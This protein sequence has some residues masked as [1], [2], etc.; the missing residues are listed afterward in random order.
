MS[1]FVIEAR[2]VSGKNRYIQSA[3]LNGAALNKPWFYHEELVKGG[4]LVLEMGPKPNEN[5]GSDLAD[6]PPSI[7]YVDYG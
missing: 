1:E 5:W 3:T 6:A 2:N 7:E 4:R